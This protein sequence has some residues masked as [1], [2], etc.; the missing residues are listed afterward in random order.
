MTELVILLAV[1]IAYGAWEALKLIWRLTLWV[2]KPIRD[3]IAYQRM[4][5]E[6]R[7][8]EQRIIE[9][10]REAVQGID[11]A[12]A[13]YVDRH[14]RALAQSDDES[15]RRQSD[16]SSEDTIAASPEPDHSTYE[17]QQVEAVAPQGYYWSW[18]AHP[19]TGNISLRAGRR[20]NAPRNRP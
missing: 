20:K 12:V 16:P 17:A 3:E 19:V 1:L 18:Y 4:V 14:E 8:K 10:H 5:R 15:R 9:A 7:K 11:A 2:T 6:E 13:S